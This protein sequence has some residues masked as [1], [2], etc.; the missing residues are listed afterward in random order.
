MIHRSLIVRSLTLGVCL[1]GIASWSI[2]A[3][4]DA[5]DEQI[6]RELNTLSYI[7]TQKAPLKAIAEYLSD[8]H[9]I[10]VALDV[11][12]LDKSDVGYEVLM[13]TLKQKDVPLRDL[14]K[15][16][17]SQH[18]NLSFMVKDHKLLFTTAAEAKNWQKEYWGEK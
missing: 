6:Y 1:A 16:V 2:A 12:M 7:D 18:D 5:R 3:D 17:L 10:P 8:L 14:L 13:F 15:T 4:R 9:S 11:E